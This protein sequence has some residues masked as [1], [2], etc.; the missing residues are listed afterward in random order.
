MTKE[1]GLEGGK[2]MYYVTLSAL[3]RGK[4]AHIFCDV[5]FENISLKVEYFYGVLTYS[6]GRSL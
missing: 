5:R 1:N 4:F 2:G 3:S 6:D